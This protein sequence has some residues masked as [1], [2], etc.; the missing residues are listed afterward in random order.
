MRIWVL[1]VEKG[2]EASLQGR[3]LAPSLGLA[4]PTGFCAFC[5]SSRLARPAPAGRQLPW[6]PREGSQGVTSPQTETSLAFLL[7]EP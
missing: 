6:G 7:R 4:I 3:L 1:I 2:W 5:A